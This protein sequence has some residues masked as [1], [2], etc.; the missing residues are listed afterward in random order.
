MALN[1]DD[2]F[3]KML[4]AA[5]SSLAD[6]W[7]DIKDLAT[8]SLRA[9]AQNLADITESVINKSTSP[10]KAKLLIDMQQATFKTVLLAEAG[11]GLLAA[12]SALNAVINA[13]KGIVNTAI[14]FAIL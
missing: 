12:E 2:I 4:S 9:L 3:E 11:L 13:I 1:L 8:T 14:G 5:K 6:S 7:T 10:E